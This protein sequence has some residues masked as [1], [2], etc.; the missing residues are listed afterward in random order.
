MHLHTHKHT[1]V[2][3]HT[4]TYKEDNVQIVPMC[5]LWNMILEVQEK[6]NLENR[7][8]EAGLTAIKTWVQQDLCVPV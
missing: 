6:S 2:H 4:Q 5:S 7:L 1:H 8:K 3:A